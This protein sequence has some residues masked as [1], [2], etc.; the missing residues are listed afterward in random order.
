M[1]AAAALPNAAPPASAPSLASPLEGAVL[2]QPGSPPNNTLPASTVVPPAATATKPDGLDERLWD[3]KT[4]SVKWP[5]LNSEVGALRAFKAEYDVRAQDVPKDANGYKIELKGV[6]VPEGME[7]KINDDHPMAKPVK[8]WAQKNNMTQTAVNELIAIQAQ[9][10]I[11]KATQFKADL[12]AEVTKLGESGRARIDAVKTA[13]VGRLGDRS[14]PLLAGLVTAE[15]VESYEALLR[16]TIASAPIPGASSADKPD[17]A[18]MSPME[19]LDY[20]H[21]KSRKAA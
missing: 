2:P 9:N 18:A 6:E 21:Q 19:R 3:G 7:L 8:A 4:N 10:E 11:S 15:Q 1:A 20:A 12:A 13:L 16:S 14:A 17:Y 5:E